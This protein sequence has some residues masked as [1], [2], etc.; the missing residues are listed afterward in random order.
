MHSKT[1]L[2]HISQSDSGRDLIS[3]AFARLWDQDNQTWILMCICRAGNAAK[4]E[5]F[6][7][8]EV[9]LFVEA[10]AIQDPK[11]MR[12]RPAIPEVP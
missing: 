9:A 5:P 8:A 10:A 7:V 12:S 3:W 11:R 1:D 6:M 2:L 4:L